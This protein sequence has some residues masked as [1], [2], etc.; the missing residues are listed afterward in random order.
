LASSHDAVPLVSINMPCYRQ[1]E[2][3]RLSIESVLSQTL[4]DFE[5]TLLDDGDSDEYRDYVK[6]LGDPRVRYHRNPVRL[7]AMQNMFAAITGGRGTY[8]LA[9]HE[10]D[11]LEPGFLAAA[12]QPMEGDPRCGFVAC[13]LREFEAAPPMVSTRAEPEYAL[14]TSP[15]AFVRGVCRAVEPM[16]GSVVYR[17]AALADAVADFDRFATLVDRPFLLSLLTR[18]TAALVVTPPLA[19]HRQHGGESDHRHLA[20]TAE[21]VLNLLQT[22]KDALPAPLSSEDEDLFHRYTGYCLLEMYHLVPPEARPS[23]GR[24]VASALLRGL[25]D[26]RYAQRYG[27]KR[28]LREVL[29]GGVAT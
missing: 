20:M 6:S 27:R 7:G 10:D 25:F 22:Y 26:L 18:W 19:W 17:R 5:L 16:F 13:Q 23:I 11:L 14:F 1:L 9:F 12:V 4:T 28:L 3:A 24:F 29:L 2:L 15:A 8:V 21:H